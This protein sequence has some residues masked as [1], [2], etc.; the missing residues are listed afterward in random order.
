VTTPG[1]PITFT[2]S[3]SGGTPGITP[4]YNWTVSAGTITAGQ[5]TP[6]ITVD[7]AGLAGRPITATVSVEGYELVC[8]ASC[9][10]AIPA[11][12]NPRQTDQYGNIARDDEKA[13]L[14]NFAIA[15]QNEPGAQGY[16]IVYAGRG[17]RAGEAARRAARAKDYLVNTRGMDAGRIVTLEGGTR[18]TLTVELW[19]V[20]AGATPPVPR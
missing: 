6:T 12:V 18:E 10:T 11:P 13:R 1:A 8:N 19:I 15:L 16:I 3:I 9:A 2:A 4:T 5:G 20:P 7:T 17:M 14:D